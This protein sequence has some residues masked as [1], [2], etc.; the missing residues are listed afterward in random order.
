MIGV[1]MGHTADVLSNDQMVRNLS[2]WLLLRKN[3]VVVLA[4]SVRFVVAK[5]KL[6]VVISGNIFDFRAKVCY[7]C[8]RFKW[9]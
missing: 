1:V 7:T 9:V 3:Q 8:N 6:P 5:H 4:I 2:V